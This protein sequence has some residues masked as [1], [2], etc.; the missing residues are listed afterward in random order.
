MQTFKDRLIYL[1]GTEAKPSKIANDIGMS[2]PGFNR[3][4]YD[5]GTPKAETL[6]KIQETTGCDLNWLLTGQGEPY[7][8]ANQP[9]APIGVA[10]QPVSTQ[11]TDT[12]GCPV[13]LNDFVFIPRYD[14]K[15]AAGR[16]EA[17]DNYNPKFTMA[18]RNYWIKNYLNTSP[19][20]LSVIEVTG[21][22]MEGLLNERDTILINH[23]KNQAGNGI[24]VL[25][26]GDDLIVKRTQTLPNKRLLVSSTNEAYAPFELDL[27]DPNSDVQIIGKVEWLG[28]RI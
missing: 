25:R 16:G 15:A 3:V 7:L 8:N 26:I 18:F 20:N 13:E 11:I 19:E 17:I 22:S 21:D 27:S 23:T 24:Y 12:L 28:R 10:E 14:V 2:T 9:K 6:V 5:G 1:W 4:W